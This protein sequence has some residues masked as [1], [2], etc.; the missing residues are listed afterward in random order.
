ME[1]NFIQFLDNL[2]LTQNQR[3]DAKKK[4]EG[5]INC[6]ARHFYDRSKNDGDQYLF[7]SY[8]TKTAIRPIEGGSDVDVLFKID[9]DTYEKY[10]NNTSGLLQECRNALKDTYST[11]EEIHAWGKVVL[12]KFCDGTHNVEV[13]PALEKDD[14]KFCIP[15]TENGGSWDDFDPRSQIDAFLDSNETTD[16][17]TRVCS[18]MI[19]NWVR[20]TS[21]LEYKSFNIVKDVILFTDK[22]YPDGKGDENY[23]VIIRDF[24]HFWIKRISDN[25]NRKSYFQ[26]ALDRANKAVEY[27]KEG[28]HI[29]ASEEWRKIFTPSLFPHSDK[30]EEKRDETKHFSIAARPWSI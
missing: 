22:I 6:M 9:K 18:M 12:V 16:G 21:T 29:E 26:T 10:K 27:E 2:K 19:K 5:V 4:Y 24:F 13:L 20:N 11:T 23:D 3:E 8:K 28:K 30:N 14:S 7:G 15:N 17:L 25:D 1:E